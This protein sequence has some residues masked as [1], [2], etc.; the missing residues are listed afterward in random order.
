MD[1]QMIKTY[2]LSK[3]GA[4]MI[5]PNFRI[6]EF[7]SPGSDGIRIDD[8]LPRVLE[9]IRAD[10]GN[11]PV[12]INSGYRTPA[13]NAAVGGAKAS[14]HMEGRAADISITGIAPV[15]VCRAA[16]TALTFYG[17]E[18]CIGLYDTYNHIDVRDK[19]YRYEKTARTGGRETAVQ[20]W[21]AAGTSNPVLKLN[22]K[23]ADV[24]RM[25]ERLIVYGFSMSPYGADGGFGSATRAAVVA[26]QKEHGLTADGIC[27]PKTWAALEKDPAQ[28]AAQSGDF[29]AQV[30]KLAVNIIVSNEGRYDSVLKS[31]N[32]KALSIGKMGWHAGRALDLLRTICKTDAANALSLLGSDLSAEIG[33]SSTNWAARKLTD[34]EAAAIRAVLGTTASKTA[35]DALAESDVTVYIRKGQ[36]YGLNDAGAL[37]YFADGVNQYGTASSLWKTIAQNALKTTGDVTA[38]YDATAPVIGTTYKSRRERTYKAVLALNL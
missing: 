36:S 28:P 22:S 13:H 10:L 34:A 25:Q 2:S 16:E 17:I 37:I 3:E 24:R 9:K 7:A 15:D 27:G 21:S 31:D 4:D 33:A 1:T 14:Q 29:V 32:G 23:G 38:M 30:A 12:R 18:G 19:R 8:R 11:K 26:F 20:G 5:S 35:Q 6:R